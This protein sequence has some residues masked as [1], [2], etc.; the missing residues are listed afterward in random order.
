MYTQTK[1]T[2]GAT[3]RAIAHPAIQQ[4]SKVQMTDN[5]PPSAT[6]QLLRSLSKG[7]MTGNQTVQRAYNEVPNANP[8][9]MWRCRQNLGIDDASLP[10]NV[11]WSGGAIAR[12]DLGG[13]SE[14][15]AVMLNLGMQ[16]NGNINVH[17]ERQPCGPCEDTL[18]SLEQMGNR[19]AGINVTAHYLVPY[20]GN[21]D[22]DLNALKGCYRGQGYIP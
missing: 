8:H 3:S 20:T 18:R 11:A 7:E 1:K 14:A 10:N 16:Q 6:V 5:R 15:K 12:S 2:R 4:K 22:T 13:H 19:N 21:S 9:T 17:T